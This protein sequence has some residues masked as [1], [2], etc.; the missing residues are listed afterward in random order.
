MAGRGIT[1]RVL[2]GAALAVCSAVGSAQADDWHRRHG[3]GPWDGRQRWHGGGPRDGWHRW[4]GGR[5]R[6]GVFIGPPPLVVRPPYYAPPPVVVA[7]PAYVVPPPVYYPPAYAS[8]CYAGPVSC[9][10]YAPQP[11]GSPCRCQAG[12]SIFPGRAG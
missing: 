12:Y 8:A 6:V 3:G 9:P 4:H 1:A 10:L 5:P 2:L 11:P 7:P